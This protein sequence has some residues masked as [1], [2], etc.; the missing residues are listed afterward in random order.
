MSQGSLFV[1]V[2]M[3]A[4]AVSV[5]WS[6]P[7]AITLP[8]STVPCTDETCE[9]ECTTAGS[10]RGENVT[11]TSSCQKSSGACNCCILPDCEVTCQE[12]RR[13]ERPRSKEVRSRCTE[14]AECYCNFLW[15]DT[16]DDPVNSP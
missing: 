13:K 8:D 4:V 9:M 10:T 1:A 14:K 2:I 16:M 6:L 12:R 7:Q 3:A 5:V 11:T 15:F